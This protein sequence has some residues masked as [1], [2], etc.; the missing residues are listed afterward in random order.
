MDRMVRK[1]VR[2]WLRLP[3]DTARA[4]F[5]AAIND[6]GLGIPC[7]TTVIPI[8]RKS[9]LERHLASTNPITAW[10][11]REPTAAAIHRISM[12]NVYVGG[13]PVMDK[14]TA[15]EVWRSALLNT[16]DGAARR[17][18]KYRRLLHRIT[19]CGSHRVFADT[20]SGRFALHQKQTILRPI[21]RNHHEPELPRQLWP[22]R[23]SLP[24]PA[25]MCGNT[26]CAMRPTQ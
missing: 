2:Q 5:H 20:A 13:Q 19:G 26:R 1:H 4:Y 23:N 25:T 14:L 18:A 21:N 6:F 17:C 11:I 22:T 16:V 7:L 8:Q 10:A 9:R 15:K 12:A 24:C 3:S